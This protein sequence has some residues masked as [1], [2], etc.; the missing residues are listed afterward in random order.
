M[1]S[2]NRFILVFSNFR[3]LRYEE[4]HDLK[5]KIEDLTNEISRKEK[6]YEEYKLQVK[7]HEEARD[8]LRVELNSANQ[9]IKDQDHATS[10]IRKELSEANARLDDERTDR[11][12]LTKQY[13]ELRET[14]TANEK[15]KLE[16]QAKMRTLEDQMFKNE[17]LRDTLQHDLQE[18]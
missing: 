11:T 13:E 1:T 2:E 5:R 18:V 15:E 3:V 6:S 12:S 4:T 17:T 10:V 16:I 9:K 8:K 14:F 7:I